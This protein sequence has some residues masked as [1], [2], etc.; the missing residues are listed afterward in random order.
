MVY[1]ML[2]LRNKSVTN[3]IYF[4]TVP[5]KNQIGIYSDFIHLQRS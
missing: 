4:I 5:L 1:R 3:M 2:G